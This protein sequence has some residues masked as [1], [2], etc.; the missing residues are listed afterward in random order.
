M[1]AKVPKRGPYLAYVLFVCV[2]TCFCL[3]PIRT[4][5]FPGFIFEFKKLKLP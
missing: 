4:L 5:H 3:S 2:Q 1:K